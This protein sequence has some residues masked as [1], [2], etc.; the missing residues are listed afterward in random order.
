MNLNPL[1]LADKQKTIVSIPV[2]L[3]IFDNNFV[4]WNSFVA[5]KS[6]NDMACSFAFSTSDFSRGKFSKW[7]I[8]I[9]DE[10][11]VMVNKKIFCIG[12]IDTIIPGYN[13]KE[14][15]IQFKGRGKTADLVDCSFTEVQAEWKKTTVKAVIEN[16][17]KP[18]GVSVTFDASVSSIVSKPVDNFKA[19]DGMFIYEL[20]NDLCADNGILAT[21][22]GDGKLTVLKATTTA[23]SKDAIVNSKNVN[24]G[25]LYQSDADRYK[26]YKVKGVGNG[27]LQK[28][29]TDFISPSGTTTDSAIKR[30]R[31][32]TIFSE[33]PTTMGG[34]QSRAVYEARI[35]AGNSRFLVYDT[36]IIQRD[37]SLWDINKLVKIQDTALNINSTLLISTVEVSMSINGGQSAELTCVDKDTYSGST[38]DI[39]IKAGFD[40]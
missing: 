11:K 2:S 21:D 16:L 6:M 23:L 27:T 13:A 31:S 26:T 33:R 10:C 17:C 8:K 18:L 39:N 30:A 19:S 29:L 12:Y 37:G 15:F 3:K 7:K 40:A 36:N 24:S 20:I 4:G 9:G 14:N 28:G 34:C 22:I 32:L 1:G 25:F 35:R 38:A 5:R